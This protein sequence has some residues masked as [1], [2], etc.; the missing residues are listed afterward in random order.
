MTAPEEAHLRLGQIPW[1]SPLEAGCEMH[2]LA[3]GVQ[4]GGGKRGGQEGGEKEEEE[5]E[6]EEKVEE[7]EEEGEE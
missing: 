6:E 5:E 3:S 2:L 1:N 4:D 7:K